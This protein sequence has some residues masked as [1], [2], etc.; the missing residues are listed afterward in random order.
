MIV[1][2]EGYGD[3]LEGILLTTSK[4]YFYMDEDVLEEIEKIDG[5][6]VVGLL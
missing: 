3:D 2:P 6:E 5:I 4:N 1:V